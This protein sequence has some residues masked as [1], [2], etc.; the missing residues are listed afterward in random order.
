MEELKPE[1]PGNP[2]GKENSQEKISNISEAD[3]SLLSPEQH[4]LVNEYVSLYSKRNELAF[5]SE[6]KKTQRDNLQ[7]E[8]TNSNIEEIKQQILE[9]ETEVQKYQNK[10]N[11]AD[12]SL[13]EIF[14]K[15]DDENKNWL[16]SG[17]PQE[18]ETQEEF[19]AKVEDRTNYVNTVMHPEYVQKPE[20]LRE[21]GPEIQEFENMMTSFQS[22]HSIDDLYAIDELDAKEASLHPVREPARLALN[23]MNAKLEVLKKETNISSDMVEELRTKF[24]YLSKAVG[25]IRDGKVLHS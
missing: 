18:V 6:K 10:I 5:N 13:S 14:I 11:E 20:S 24:K 23:P 25:F 21:A 3:K 15:I 1:E 19:L 8:I 7:A 17:F 2:E 4:K 9:A 16:E 12:Q 22:E